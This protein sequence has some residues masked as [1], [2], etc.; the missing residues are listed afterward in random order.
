MPEIDQ[1]PVQTRDEILQTHLVAIREE[2]HD[3]PKRIF[4]WFLGFWIICAILYWIMITA[5]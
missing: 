2:I 3:L 5:P 4:S 1:P